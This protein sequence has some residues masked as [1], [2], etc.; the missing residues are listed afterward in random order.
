[1]VNVSCC[2]RDSEREARTSHPQSPSDKANPTDATIRT[3]GPNCFARRCRTGVYGGGRHVLASAARMIAR[4]LAEG[5][6]A[7]ASRRCPA[8]EGC[9]AVARMERATLWSFGWTW[10]EDQLPQASSEC[11]T[12]YGRDEVYVPAEERADDHCN[13]HA[14]ERQ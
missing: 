4:A 2:H 12:R 1:M 13:D 8:E 10:V 6:T 11:S 5:S 7:C 9:V 3:P 14:I